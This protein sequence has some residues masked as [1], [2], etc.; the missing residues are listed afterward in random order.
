[1]GQLSWLGMTCAG[2]SAMEVELTLDIE[3]IGSIQVERVE[4]VPGRL[5]LPGLEYR[6]RV[7]DGRVG[8]RVSDRQF[9]AA[10]EVTALYE[11]RYTLSRGGVDIKKML[12]ELLREM[13]NDE[14]FWVDVE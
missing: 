6:G 7:W 2:E 8:F 9:Q 10:A 1:M 5:M 13:E 3:R 11:D 4:T 14:E 12:D